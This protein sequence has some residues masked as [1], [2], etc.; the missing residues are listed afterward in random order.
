[1]ATP[2]ISRRTASDPRDRAAAD[3]DPRGRRDYPRRRA[4]DLGDANERDLD[5]RWRADEANVMRLRGADA[6][7][8]APR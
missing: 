2:D 8:H 5:A 4:V 1:M 6:D 3:R 7:R